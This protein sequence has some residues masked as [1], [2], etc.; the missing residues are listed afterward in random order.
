[1]G[2]HENKIYMVEFEILTAAS[3]K[4]AFVWFEALCSVVEVLKCYKNPED[5]RFAYQLGE[6]FL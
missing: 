4:M 1:M 3:V 6:Q 2:K 5:L